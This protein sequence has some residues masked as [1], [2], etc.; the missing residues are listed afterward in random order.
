[1]EDC[2]EHPPSLPLPPHLKS[3]L[4]CT[5]SL[6][7]HSANPSAHPQLPICSESQTPPQPDDP[8]APPWLTAPSSPPWPVSPLAPPGSLLPPSLPWSAVDHL[9]PLDSTPLASPR[10]SLPPAPLGPLLLH[11]HCGTWPSGSSLLHPWLLYHRLHFRQLESSALPPPWL[12]PP[13]APPW[14]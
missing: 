8:S 13:S 10:S 7:L 14:A 11:I 9:L 3:S 2:H 1:F 5:A 12:L 6:P 4:L